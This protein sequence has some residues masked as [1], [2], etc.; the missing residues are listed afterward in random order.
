MKV[1][2]LILSTVSLC[3]LLS[4][5]SQQPKER[6]VMS[7]ANSPTRKRAQAKIVVHHSKAEPYDE[8]GE[9]TLQELHLNETFSGDING[10]SPVRALQVMRADQSASL[11]SVQRFR[12]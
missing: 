5:E 12:G 7:T 10:E 11:V 4:A 9:P 8:A 1:R 2:I 6:A 3:T